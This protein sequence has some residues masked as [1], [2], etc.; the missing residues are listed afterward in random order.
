MR[1]CYEKAA[2]GM[3]KHAHI[4]QGGTSNTCICVTSYF[5]G[6][7]ADMTQIIVLMQVWMDVGRHVILFSSF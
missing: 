5:C 2:L 3:C 4:K 6:A 7:R 1:K